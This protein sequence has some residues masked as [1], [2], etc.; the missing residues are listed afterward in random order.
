MFFLNRYLNLYSNNLKNK[1]IHK[2][3]DK[4]TR[5]MKKFPCKTWKK[6]SKERIKCLTR[7]QKQKQKQK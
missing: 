7:K 6:N 1:S 3:L 4:L 2:K 5:D